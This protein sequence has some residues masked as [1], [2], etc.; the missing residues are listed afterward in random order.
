MHAALS[1]SRSRGK[2]TRTHTRAFTIVELVVVIVIVGVV[3]AVSV[4]SLASLGD[5]RG[6]AAGRRLVHDLSYAREVAL[7]AG[8]RSW[9]KFNT[10]G[11]TYSLFAE[12]TSSPGLIS[13]RELVDP[14]TGFAYVQR[15]A[16]DPFPGVRLTGVAIDGSVYLGF[17]WMGAPLNATESPIST[18]AVITLSSG[19]TISVEPQSGSITM[20]PNN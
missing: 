5:T 4:T 7:S 18:T 16:A 20:V 1:T 2:G 19:H 14:A 6:G 17:D 15:L 9:V 12:T 8:S 13:S 11:Q 3:S 10:E